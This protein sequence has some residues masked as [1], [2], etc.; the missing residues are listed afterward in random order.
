[1][2]LRA[3]HDFPASTALNRQNPESNRRILNRRTE[4]QKNRATEEQNNRETEE[5]RNRTT[6]QQNNRETEEQNN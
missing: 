6:E 4:E 1:M 5:Q 2:P 3:L